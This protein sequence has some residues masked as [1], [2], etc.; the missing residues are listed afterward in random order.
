[1]SRINEL[2]AELCPDE[3]PYVEI[4]SVVRLNFGTRITKKADAGIEAHAH[5]RRVFDVCS[6]G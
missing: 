5:R 1:M 3:V 6:G 2:I 4:D